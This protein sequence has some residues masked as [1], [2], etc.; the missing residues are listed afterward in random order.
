VT[1]ITGEYGR[2]AESSMME[3]PERSPRTGVDPD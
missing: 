1:G 2:R 3:E